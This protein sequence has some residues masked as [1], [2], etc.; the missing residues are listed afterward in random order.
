MNSAAAT[1]SDGSETGLERP[2][3]GLTRRMEHSDESATCPWLAARG[4][5][6]SGRPSDRW[7]G[8]PFVGRRGRRPR[9][10]TPGAPDVHAH[11]Q[12]ARG[13]ARVRD[14]RCDATQHKERTPN[15]TRCMR[16][17]AI[18]TYVLE[19]GTVHMHHSTR[20]AKPQPSP[21][22]E[23]RWD[24]QSRGWPSPSQAPHTRASRTSLA[25]HSHAV[26]SR[27]ASRRRGP[28]HGIGWIR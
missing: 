21:P 20:L 16:G 15:S 18:C 4:S 5:S 23:T 1:R 6:T 9:I 25:R 12:R 11:A 17:R 19:Y 10:A 26:P 24:P 27:A 2:A 14:G 22:H 28:A 8:R 3:Q 7:A 13:A